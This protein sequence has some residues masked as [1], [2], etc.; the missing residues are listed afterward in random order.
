MTAA[1]GLVTVSISS[2]FHKAMNPSAAEAAQVAEALKSPVSLRAAPK[3]GGGSTTTA[4][5]SYHRV[6]APPPTSSASPAAI[7]FLVS[8]PTLDA[9]TTKAFVD[10]VVASVSD[11]LIGRLLIRREDME[12]FCVDVCATF[13]DLAP[14]YEA[15][16]PQRLDL[17]TMRTALCTALFGG[18]EV[19]LTPEQ[20]QL[21]NQP[22]AEL[23]FSAITS[24]LRGTLTAKQLR[25]LPFIITMFLAVS[26]SVMLS[27]SAS[28]VSGGSQSKV[29]TR[30]G[31]TGGG[32]GSAV[33]SPATPSVNGFDVARGGEALLTACSDWLVSNVVAPIVERVAG[34]VD[35]IVSNCLRFNT[36]ETTTFYVKQA[37]SLKQ[38]AHGQILPAFKARWEEFLVKWLKSPCVLAVLM[39]LATQYMA[40]VNNPS[41]FTGGGGGAPS[42]ARAV[43]DGNNNGNSNIGMPPPSIAHTSAPTRPTLFRKG[44]TL[45]SASHVS[46]QDIRPK[47]SESLAEKFTSLKGNQSLVSGV[48]ESLPAPQFATTDQ[49][50]LERIRLLQALEGGRKLGNS[51]QARSTTTVAPAAASSPEIAFRVPELLSSYLV[52]KHLRRGVLASTLA[53]CSLK[54]GANEYE[55]LSGPAAQWKGAI[56]KLGSTFSAKESNADSR[57]VLRHSIFVAKRRVAQGLPESEVGERPPLVP[58]DS[59][60]E[61][62]FA[63]HSVSEML[64]KFY[65]FKVA[66]L[67]RGDGGATTDLRQPGSNGGTTAEGATEEAGHTSPIPEPIALSSQTPRRPCHE[68]VLTLR[69]QQAIS[70]LRELLTLIITVFETAMSMPVLLYGFEMSELYASTEWSQLGASLAT[71][72]RNVLKV[73]GEEGVQTGL[74]RP[75]DDEGEVDAKVR[76]GDSIAPSMPL[77]SFLK[78]EHTSPS[79]SSFKLSSLL[80]S[81]YLV[82][83]LVWLPQ[84]VRVMLGG[85][86]GSGGMSGS[87]PH[88][89]A[90]TALAANVVTPLVEEL[91]AWV[92]VS[93]T[94]HTVVA[95]K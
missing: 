3:R 28:K 58:C 31:G 24:S 88:E 46:Q 85:G 7:D 49:A 21:T 65:R 18:D 51:S 40:V 27:P 36:A 4:H 78:V 61:R 72:P 70:E 41:T 53:S 42:D 66:S 50:K 23:L 68:R 56:A 74:K 6:V 39:D 62:L 34:Q 54:S 44:G 12:A 84:I 76:V 14:S 77:P 17:G 80:S 87:L 8:S 91:L 55:G 79:P 2:A 13:P 5:T 11:T 63:T 69:N 89:H 64:D 73:E 32:D 82:R 81:E 20:Q 71:E 38:S 57:E 86:G 90:A 15:V 22:Y 37:N 35:L 10:G 16:C 33:A 1:H 59:A 60:L 19:P 25:E 52:T 45:P 93:D 47:P 83:L 9:M 26:S 43:G 94:Q 75:R 48:A 29:S 30:R 92:E 95:S 67:M